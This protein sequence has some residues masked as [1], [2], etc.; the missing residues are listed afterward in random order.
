LP[1]VLLLLPS[2]VCFLYLSR[3]SEASP[4]CWAV[5]GGNSLRNCTVCYGLRR[6]RIQAQDY[7]I[8]VKFA[9]LGPTVFLK[10]P[11]LAQKNIRKNLY[12]FMD[13]IPDGYDKIKIFLNSPFKAT[14]LY[15]LPHLHPIPPT[16]CFT[17]F[18]LNLSGSHSPSNLLSCRLPTTWP[19]LPCHFQ[20]LS[21]T[22]C[23]A[24]R[25]PYSP[26][27]PSPSALLTFCPLTFYPTCL[28]P[29]SPFVPL[30]ICPTT[31]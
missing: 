3:P 23:P 1:S 13:G 5:Q 27:A 19:Q 12:P 28:L 9:A 7:C 30:Y 8:A 18:L 11:L 16:H 29:Y 24:H 14:Y 4:R 25:L 6:C 15:L 31:F 22:F 21:I 17:R 2:V 10:P 20:S 26:S